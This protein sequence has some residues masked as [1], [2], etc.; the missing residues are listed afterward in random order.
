MKNQKVGV[1]WEKKSPKGEVYFS[2]EI[3]VNGR[4]VKIVVFKNGHKETEKHPDY[5]ILL[6]NER[7][8]G[9]VTEDYQE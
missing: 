3:I 4:P 7:K 2:G 8:E 1:L 6:S 5:R 9:I